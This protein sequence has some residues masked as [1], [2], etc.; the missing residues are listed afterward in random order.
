MEN[1]KRTDLGDQGV[2]RLCACGCG[3]IIRSSDPRTRYIN[4]NHKHKAY[5]Q[6]KIKKYG[7]K[8]RKQRDRSTF[9][10]KPKNWEVAERLLKNA[11]ILYN[12]AYGHGRWFYKSETA[13]VEGIEFDWLYYGD[14]GIRK[15]Y[16]NRMINT[17]LKHNLLERQ[18]DK[19][20]D[21][22]SDDF[23]RIMNYQYRAVKRNII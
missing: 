9:K 21:L 8:K 3:K 7:K 5:L 14:N 10:G 15:N 13:D 1:I 19:D 11:E 22:L 18:K 4:K 12:W 16:W 17:M 2:L 23:Y 20:V 6:R